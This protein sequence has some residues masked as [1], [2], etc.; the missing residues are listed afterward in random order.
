MSGCGLGLFFYLAPLSKRFFFII[1]AI[2]IGEEKP[3]Y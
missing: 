3:E 2:F 1:A